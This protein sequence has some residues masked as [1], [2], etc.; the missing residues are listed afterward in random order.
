MIAVLIE[1]APA[2]DTPR[3]DGIACSIV[4]CIAYPL[5][6]LALFVVS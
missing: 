2:P 4:L 3:C 1:A 5:L 6:S